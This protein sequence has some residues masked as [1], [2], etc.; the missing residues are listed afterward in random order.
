M[1]KSTYQAAEKKER[2][3]VDILISY[4]VEFK[5]KPVSRDKEIHF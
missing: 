5:K 2:A 1:E 4:K 3:V